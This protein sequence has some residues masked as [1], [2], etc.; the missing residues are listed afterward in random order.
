[1]ELSQSP[2]VVESPSSSQIQSSSSS[3]DEVE[4]EAEPEVDPDPFDETEPDSDELSARSAAKR[5]W[6][7]AV[8]VV[9]VSELEGKLGV[10]SNAE[11]DVSTALVSASAVREGSLVF[12]AVLL[13]ASS[14]GLAIAAGVFETVASVVVAED[15]SSPLPP[16]NAAIA[17]E[18]ALFCA[19]LIAVEVGAAALVVFLWKRP[20]MISKIPSFVVVAVAV[21]VAVAGAPAELLWKRPPI[22]SQKL[23]FVVVV[24]GV[25]PVAVA[26][27]ADVMDALSS[28]PS[29]SS[30][31]ED[32]VPLSLFKR[33]ASKP[34]SSSSSS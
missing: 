15:E 34:L 3:S 13:L 6:A 25:E 29:S 24:V 32:E 8:E 20:A 22:I 5:P 17:S 7:L 19:E 11:V 12:A 27:V 31:E 2:V 33:S 4:D 10:D 28:H 18:R 16:R 21:P 1:M 23:F 30:S 26:V 14:A 9:L